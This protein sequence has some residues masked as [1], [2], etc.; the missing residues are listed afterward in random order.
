MKSGPTEPAIYRH[1]AAAQAAPL[2]L[3]AARVFV[4][5]PIQDRTDDEM[6]ARPT[7]RSTGSW[8]PSLARRTSSLSSRHESVVEVVEQCEHLIAGVDRCAVVEEEGTAG[9]SGC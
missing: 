8:P 6:A 3:D 9:T 2:G 5:H 1:A 4:A 7:P